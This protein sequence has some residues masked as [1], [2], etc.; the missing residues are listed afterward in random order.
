M[1]TRSGTTELWAMMA[2]LWM[3]APAIATAAS[4]PPS[5]PNNSRTASLVHDFWRFVSDVSTL[6]HP[7]LSSLAQRHRPSRRRRTAAHPLT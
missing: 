3:A 1:R 7:R 5:D 6:T 4:V 2:M